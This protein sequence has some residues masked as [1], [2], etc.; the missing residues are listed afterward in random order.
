MKPTA[1]LTNPFGGKDKVKMNPGIGHPDLVEPAGPTDP[2]VYFVSV[3]SS[4]GRPICLLANYSL[5]YVG[6]VPNN[7]ISSDYFGV[8]AEQ[9]AKLV[10]ADKKAPGFVAMMSNGTSGNINNINFRGP[11]E[12]LPSYQKMQ[13]VARDVANEV[14]KGY[15]KLEYKADVELG[16]TFSNLNLEVRKPT[17]EMLARAKQVVANPASV[18]LY[19]PL[20]ETYAKRAIQMQ[21]RW[22]ERVDVVI[23]NLKIGDLGIAAIPFET[24]V[25]I[26][27]DI[28]M[29][30]P[31][32]YTFISMLANGCVGYVPTQQAMAKGGGGYE[33]RLTLYSN[34]EVGAGERMAAIGV[35]LARQL[36]PGPI[37]SGQ[38][39]PAFSG[40]PWEYGSIA[41]ELN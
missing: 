37:P 1:D 15:Q 20:E 30:S 39:A 8:F 38:K 27:L 13:I 26:G 12:K 28:K 32:E 2:E 18:K 16:A 10:E 33:T 14:F 31:F 19:H 9:F 5:H 21:E 34:L 40:K 29:N 7:H 22:P 24:F 36:Q 3:Q 41:P 4:D 23:Q 25:E 17:P 11:A 6:G 35:E